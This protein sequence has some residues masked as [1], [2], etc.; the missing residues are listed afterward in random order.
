MLYGTSRDVTIMNIPFLT[1]YHFVLKLEKK[2]KKVN[3]K[4]KKH[5]NN[6]NN[7]NNKTHLMCVRTLSMSGK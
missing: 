2:R 4:Q 7:N 1:P 5:N 6:N 3:K